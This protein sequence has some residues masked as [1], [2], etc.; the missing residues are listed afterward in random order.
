[1]NPTSRWRWAA[2]LWPAGMLFVVM[3]TANHW[4]LDAAGG[5]AAVLLALAI[6]NPLTRSLPRP[7]AARQ[8]QAA[9]A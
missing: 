5:A 4:W 6:V 8:L 2:F 9:A 3:S 7:W 1:M